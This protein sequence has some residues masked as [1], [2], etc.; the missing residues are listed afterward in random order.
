[1]TQMTCRMAHRQA[2]SG[3]AE[4][5]SANASSA[6]RTFGSE[7]SADAIGRPSRSFL[8]VS[9]HFKVAILL[10]VISTKERLLGNHDPVPPCRSK[11]GIQHL[12]RPQTATEPVSYDMRWHRL[13]SRTRSCSR[14]LECLRA[15][16]SSFDR[17]A[18]ED[19]YAS[20]VTVTLVLTPRRTRSVVNTCSHSIAHEPARQSWGLSQKVIVAPNTTVLPARSR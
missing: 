9:D 20:T 14:R 12:I 10:D 7:I 15:V 19:F 11:A 17:C 4:T 1:M 3:S 5:R 6:T 13:R 8:A 18:G 2:S 16:L